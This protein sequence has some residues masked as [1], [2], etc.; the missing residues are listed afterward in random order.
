L[1]QAVVIDESKF[2]SV[3]QPFKFEDLKKFVPHMISSANAA[4]V[5]HG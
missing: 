4:K 5:I 1:L 3:E 2:V